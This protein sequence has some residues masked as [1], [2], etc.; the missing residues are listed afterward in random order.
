MASGDSGQTQTSG[1]S[2]TGLNFYRPERRIILLLFLAPSFYEIWWYW[3]LFA[4]TRR[5]GFPRAR[6]FWWI[7]VPIYGWI[8]MF[9]QFDDL[10]QAAA[11]VSAPALSSRV[12]IAL[13]IGSWWA[14]AASSRTSTTAGL[15]LIIISGVLLAWL[16]YVVQPSAN[17][18]LKTRYPDAP[19]MGMTWGEIVAA[20]LGVLLFLLVILGALL[21]PA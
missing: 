2:T 5:E 3:Q 12:A 21:P 17:G 13:L 19:M 14:G 7:L 20:S 1:P 16:G 8:V 10:K 15:V 6:A 9:R 4:F 18:Y 11:R